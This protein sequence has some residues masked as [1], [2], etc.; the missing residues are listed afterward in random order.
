MTEA[1]P[2]FAA[3]GI[4][5]VAISVDS[6]EDSLEFIAN[7]GIGVPLLSDPE[8]GVIKAYGVAMVS[9]NIAV[10]ATFIVGAD[11]RVRWRHVGETMMD[12][13]DALQVLDLVQKQ[14]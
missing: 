10:P 1:K 13:P 4:P 12:R 3:A 8:M 7:K 6:R 2:Q 14:K 5:V 9:E 11:G